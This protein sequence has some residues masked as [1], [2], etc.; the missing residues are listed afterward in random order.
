MFVNSTQNLGV[1]YNSE[2]EG[3]A[4]QVPVPISVPTISTTQQAEEATHT[5]VQVPQNTQGPPVTA[6]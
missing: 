6:A 2:D 3:Y 4:R 1:V 5:K